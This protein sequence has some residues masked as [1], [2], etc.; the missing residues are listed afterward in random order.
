MD[1]ALFKPALAE[2]QNS[3]GDVDDLSSGDEDGGLD[4]TKLQ[5]TLR[6][7]RPVIPKRGEKEFEPAPGGGSGLQMHVLDR[8]R[9]AMFDTLRAE[10]TVSS[11]SISYGIWY[12]DISRTQVTLNRGVHFSVMGHSAPRPVLSDDG[13][14][15]LH[16]RLEL[17]P[18]ETLYLIERG[19]MLCWKHAAELD[20]PELH[21]GDLDAK[22]GGAPMSVQ[23]AYSELVGREDL[24]LE[25][26]QVFAYLRRLGYVVTRTS[27]PTP[28]YPIPPLLCPKQGSQSSSLV[29]RFIAQIRGFIMAIWGKSVSRQK[30]MWSIAVSRSWRFKHDWTYNSILRSLRIVPAGH[31]VPLY[32]AFNSKKAKI[33]DKEKSTPGGKSPYHVFYNVYKPSTPFRKSA[34]GQPDFCM[35]VVNARTTCAPT[36]HELSVLFS[37]LPEH[38]APRPRKRNT[39][40]AKGHNEAST[41]P[42]DIA[43]LSDVAPSD[44]RL[45]PSGSAAG[46]SWFGKLWHRLVPSSCHIVHS[47]MPTKKKSQPPN[48]FPALKAGKKTVI[49]AAVDHGNISFFR[50]SEGVF[51]DWEML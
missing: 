50:F 4:W 45:A 24:S 15:K 11:K 29:T 6:S 30:T 1:D 43:K 47:D 13:S 36:I 20:I 25:K 27:P 17:L 5:S 9:N 23:Q 16:K 28:D 44:S 26:Y 42:A 10:R 40:P 32:A 46:T 2:K 22:I 31:S 38:G 35:A 3:Q 41:T 7:A 49:V 12:P 14:T 51:E 18:E 34:P 39:G 8:A 48:P 33:S 37:G 19:T 21:S